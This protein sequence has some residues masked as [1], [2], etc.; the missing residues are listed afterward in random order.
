MVLCP[1]SRH[2]RTGKGVIDEVS[3]TS[4]Q[5]NINALQEPNASG[6]S[7]VA[8]H[9]DYP[10]KWKQS[11]GRH[12]ISLLRKQVITSDKSLLSLVLNFELWPFHTHKQTLLAFGRE[13]RHCLISEDRR[14]QVLLGFRFSLAIIHG[15]YQRYTLVF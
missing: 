3:L 7:I 9:P 13:Y 15:R 2:I 10:G 5:T 14:L 8:P 11:L 1:F 4:F 12:C 6:K